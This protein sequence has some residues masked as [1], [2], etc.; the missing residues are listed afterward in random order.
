MNQRHV[1]GM[2]GLWVAAFCVLFPHVGSA[3]LPDE[4]RMPPTPSVTPRSLSTG[5]GSGGV[6]SRG[7]SVQRSVVFSSR[8]LQPS[9]G[10]TPA[11]QRQ[12]DRLERM[13]QLLTQKLDP[14]THTHHDGS[15]WVT[16]D[17]QEYH[18]HPDGRYY[19][20]LGGPDATRGYGGGSSLP[21]RE[22]PITV[23]DSHRDGHLQAYLPLATAEGRLYRN[24]VTRT[25]D[26]TF[27]ARPMS[28]DSYRDFMSDTYTIQP[29]QD[30]IKLLTIGS[31][32][33]LAPR[34]YFDYNIHARYNEADAE[35]QLRLRM[36]DRPIHV[37]PDGVL[38]YHPQDNPW[39]HVEF[40]PRF[41]FDGLDEIS[42]TG[43]VT[44]L[45][46]QAAYHWSTLS[47]LIPGTG[48]R[49]SSDPS[50]DPVTTPTQQAGG[51]TI[52]RK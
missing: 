31:I 14:D 23:R 33:G 5:G 13:E 51:S 28:H 34:H 2:L 9:V 15:R 49:S 46:P 39:E 52:Q 25:L 32:D 20:H 26:L 19:L 18:Q 50:G 36:G 4:A 27:A 12:F 11:P 17:G 41:H 43:K 24:S 8:S 16:I 44:L 30:E 1:R 6:I 7:M 21:L 47:T 22:V 35:G 48:V 42:G 10:M 38:S 45:K 29:E 3:H 40:V 37:H